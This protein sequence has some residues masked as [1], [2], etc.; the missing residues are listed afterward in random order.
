MRWILKEDSVYEKKIEI[1]QK[2]SDHNAS[3]TTVPMKLS[4]AKKLDISK[5]SGFAMIE[6]AAT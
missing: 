2:K 1:K 3:S 6:L 4:A 5:H